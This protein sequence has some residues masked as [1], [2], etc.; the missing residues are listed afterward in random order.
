[1]KT[2]LNKKRIIVTGCAGFVGSNLVDKLIPLNHQIIGIDNLSTGQKKFLRHALK[3]KNFKFL[4][5][6]LLNLKKIKKNIQR[7]R[8]Y[9]SLSCKCRRQIWL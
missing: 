6:D 8:F 7:F 4:K 3:Y 1:M 2:N 5:C 9:F